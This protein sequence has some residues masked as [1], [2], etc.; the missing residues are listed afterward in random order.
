MKLLHEYNTEKIRVEQYNN[1]ETPKVEEETEEKKEETILSP[2]E[3]ANAIS[4]GKI[5]IDELL[6]DKE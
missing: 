3:L 2:F 4:R 6:K 5:D 1:P